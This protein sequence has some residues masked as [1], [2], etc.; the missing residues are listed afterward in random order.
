MQKVIFFPSSLSRENYS[1]KIRHLENSHKE[2]ETFRKA[3]LV[4]KLITIFCKFNSSTDSLNSQVIKDAFRL[5][6]WRDRMDLGAQH[7]IQAS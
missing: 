7:G 1:Y 3:T 4:R 2:L 6:T 5:L